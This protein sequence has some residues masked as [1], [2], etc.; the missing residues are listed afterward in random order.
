M[1]KYRRFEQK[2]AFVFSKFPKAKS[3]V[4]KFYQKLNYIRYKKNYNYRSDYPIKKN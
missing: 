2:V 4:K 3:G 1:T